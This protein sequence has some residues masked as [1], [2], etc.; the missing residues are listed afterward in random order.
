MEFFKATRNKV[1]LDGHQNVVDF[2]HSDFSN[3]EYFLYF[4]YADYK[5]LV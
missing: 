4:L 5:T 1:L 2:T 3:Y